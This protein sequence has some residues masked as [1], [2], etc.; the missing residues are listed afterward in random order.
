MRGGA[1]HEEESGDRDGFQKDWV[2]E[3]ENDVD[4][5]P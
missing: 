2:S 3:D 1:F 5:C 4:W